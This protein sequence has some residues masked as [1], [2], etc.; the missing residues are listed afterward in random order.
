MS[1]AAAKDERVALGAAVEVP[2]RPR[3]APG[4]ELLGQMQDT[5]FVDRQWLIQREGAFLQVTELLY[6]VAEQID[7]ERTLEEIAAELTASTDWAVTA[8]NVRQV[9]LAK[10]IPM[11][12]VLTAGDTVAPRADDREPSPLQINLRRVM[13]GPRVIDPVTRVL[14]YLYAPAVLVPL[15]LVVATAYGWLYLVRGVGDAFRAALY[16]PGGLLVVLGV[17]IASGIVHEFGHAAALRYGGGKV[18]GMGIGLY[19]VYPTFYTDTTDAY[20]L[21]RWARLRTDLGGIYFHLLFGL[22]LIALY[23]V[24]GQELLLAIVLVISGDILYQ[25]IPYLR[26]D[27][28][29]ALTDLTG[30]P[31]FFSQ[32]G[33][34]LRSVLPLPGA[35]G[36]KLPTLKRAAKIAFAAYIA[37]TIPV[38]AILTAF[39]LWGFPRFMTT[40]WGA[41]RHQAS[42]FTQAWSAGDAFLVAA[43]IAQILLLA[44]SMLA[45]AYFLYSLA[46]R[47]LKGLWTWSRPTLARRTAGTLGATAATIVLVAMWAPEFLLRVRMPAG[48]QRFPIESRLHVMTPV[49]YPQDPPVGGNHYPIWQ[50]CGFYDAPID[51]EKGVHSLEHG[52]VWIT[53]RPDL[54]RDQVQVLGRLAH[55]ESHILVS[56][57]PG[58][59]APVVA[60]AWGYQARLRSASDPLLGEFVHTFRVGPQAPERGGPCTLGIGQP[61]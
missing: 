20:R 34:F 1:N 42:V 11:G 8:D 41:V 44:L 9:L 61:E 5:G 35:S 39:M 10:L 27:G 31:D 53:F 7:G 22:A 13:L 59:A 36:G 12:L 37:L 57:Y 48:V 40:A 49:A 26:L 43:V 50:N 23:F 55:H 52:A 33:P 21:G 56:P 29:W 17:A 30:I 45:A 25:L 6:R 19:I 4:V 18:R 28:Y 54:P 3:L 2:E 32:T 60:S 46:Q 58:L 24:T 15:L 14:R 51:R 16:T 38:L 47:A